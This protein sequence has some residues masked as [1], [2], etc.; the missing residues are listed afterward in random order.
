MP[1]VYTLVVDVSRAEGDGLPGDCD[2][3]TM[4][5]FASGTDEKNAVDETVKVLRE[6]GLSPVEVQCCGIPSGRGAE[7]QQIPGDERGL[8]QRALDE[9]AVVVAQVVPFTEDDGDGD[10]KMLHGSPGDA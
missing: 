10:G 6:A 9:N 7:G 5:C 8:M 4:L 3:A 1:E 2:G